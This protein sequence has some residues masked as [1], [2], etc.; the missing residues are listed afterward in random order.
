MAE[1]RVRITGDSSG[2]NQTL[3]QSKAQA[4]RFGQD[5]QAQQARSAV[6]AAKI[7]AGGMRVAGAASAL[8]GTPGMGAAGGVAGA[9]AAAFIGLKESA[10]MLGTS[11]W[12]LAGI[13]GAVAFA[14]NR[15]S[16]LIKEAY[17]L[18][19]HLNEQ[20]ETDVRSHNE[21]VDARKKYAEVLDKNA[22]TLKPEDE[23]RLRK[24]IE[25]S[26]INIRNKAFAEI[27]SRFGGTESNKELQ[28]DL[29][30]ARIEAMP[31]GAPRELAEEQL[32]FSQEQE[33]LR[34]RLGATPSQ[35]TSMLVRQIA[36]A[37]TQEHNNRIQ[38]I[39]TESLAQQKK[40]AGNTKPYNP[41]R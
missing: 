18:Q 23:K 7:G 30:K 13:L 5:I 3:A 10:T 14:F 11:I 9:A 1:L 6:A 37:M 28:K 16:T 12:K 4:A 22:S 27:R 24:G 38:E 26:D 33:N 15:Y 39:L 29:V 21:V 2:F 41:F 8:S 34:G 40:I 20:L 25:S 32:R 35:A 17:G 19:K 31:K 36:Q